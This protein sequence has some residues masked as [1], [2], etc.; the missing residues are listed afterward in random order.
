MEGDLI[1]NANVFYTRWRDQ[2]V[3]RVDPG[4]LLDQFIDN[5]G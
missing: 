2:Q 4:G 5:A 3:V 1:I